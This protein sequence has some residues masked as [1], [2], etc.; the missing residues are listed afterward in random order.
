MGFLG[1]AIA[2]ADV[3]S[4]SVE[5]EGLTKSEAAG[6]GLIAGLTLGVII[7]LALVWY[8]LQVIADWKIFTKAGVE[9]W[10]SIIPVYNYYVEYS[11]CW[12]AIFGLVFGIASVVLAA[13]N[14]AS[15]LPSWV[16]TL[17]SILG[18]AAFVLHC[19]ESVKL[20][21]AFG[22]G[23]GFGICLIL[24]GPICRLILGFGKARYIGP[25]N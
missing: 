18:T 1:R 10:K 5:L 13:V 4:I 21:K 22:K 14:S 25:N 19:I 3:N 11:I 15:N 8:V 16:T 2:E 6:V 7:V 9:G 12:E 20:S 24:F 17:T 23:T